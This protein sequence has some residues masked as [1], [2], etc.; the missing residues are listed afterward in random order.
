VSNSIS[1]KLLAKNTIWNFSGLIFPLLIGIFSIPILIEG[2]GK[3]RFGLLTIIWMGVGYF[4]LFDM[5]LS[6][7]LT[8]LISERLGNNNADENFGSLI[9]SALWLIIS[10][11][12]LA[13]ILLGLS[14]T[15]LT[16]NVLLVPNT[17]IQEATL[18]L[19][20]LSFG[21]PFVILTTA[22]I[23]ILEAHQNFRLITL[24][25]IPLGLLTFLG[26]L[27]TLQFT[28]SLVWATLAML[29]GRIIACAIYFMAA[30]SC[31]RELLEPQLPSKGETKALFQFGGWL[32]VTNII[33]PLMV[34]FDR[35]LI[36][37]II[38]M[39]A[40]TYYVTPFEVLSRLQLITAAIM[41]VMFPAL[42]RL[43]VNE[44]KRLFFLY[45]KTTQ[46]LLLIILPITTFIFLFAPDGLALWLGKDFSEE[47]TT[48]VKLLAIGWLINILAQG[49]FTIL[50]SHG[51]PD[52]IAKTHIAELIPYGVMLWFLT[53]RYGISGTAMAWVLRVLIDTIILN[54]LVWVHIPIIRKILLRALVILVLIIIFAG[55]T[56]SINEPYFR[57]GLFFIVVLIIA[58]QV[59]KTIKEIFNPTKKESYDQS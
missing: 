33:G 46:S 25:R 4:S 43:L 19:I 38:S 18:A 22:M 21:L 28:P 3:E 48:V 13:S 52:L 34:Y 42:T 58:P 36:G 14:S 47:S 35:F 8:K 59:F 16:Q 57:M 24:I 27:A 15:A 9:W 1:S 45:S 49:P 2:M 10:F 56:W 50:Q 12:F 23:G 29:L 5:G 40:V 39:S 37:A 30:T 53:N 31:R 6:R 44:P 41:G 20:I 32:T 7:A 51:R 26:P 11:G 17:L 55:A 54:S